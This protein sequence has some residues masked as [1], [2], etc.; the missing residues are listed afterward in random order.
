MLSKIYQS[1]EAILNCMSEAVY[2]TDLDMTIIYA[3]PSSA[4]LTGYPVDEAI[5]RKCSGVFCEASD[6]CLGPCPPKAAVRDRLPILHREAETRTRDGEI[7]NTQISFSPFFEGEQ[8]LGTVIVIKD[9]TE[10]RKAQEKISQQNRFLKLI[11]D[12]LP[13]PFYVIDVRDYTIQIANKA[14]RDTA[15]GGLTCYANTHERSEPCRSGE[16]P[17]P[18][19]EVLRT[20][21]PCIVEHLHR[22]AEGVFRNCEVHGYPIFDEQGNVVQMIEYA[23]DITE[24]KNAEEQREKLIAELQEALAQVRT[25]SGLLPICASCKNIRDDDGYWTQIEAY[26]SKYSGVA[27]THGLC[28]DCARKLYPGVYREK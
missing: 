12:S 9:I 8:C 5:G 7:K 27:F 1:H 2:V 6:R 14:V 28:P 19:A 16:H 10:I 24:R 4:L 18:L 3:N 11:I 15:L 17:C 25:L 20:K 22:D 26:I 13:N 23:L 21:Q